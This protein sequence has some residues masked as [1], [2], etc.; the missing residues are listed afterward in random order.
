M[1]ER[2]RAFTFDVFPYQMSQT[3]ALTS[4]ALPIAKLWLDGQFYNLLQKCRNI[5]PQKLKKLFE[6]AKLCQ[7]WRK[8]VAAFVTVNLVNYLLHQ[9]EK[10]QAF[11]IHF[12]SSSKLPFCEQRWSGLCNLDYI[13]DYTSGFQ[14]QETFGV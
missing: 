10:F 14:C 2:K 13:C 12:C 8:V 7:E 9:I 4:R 11:L 1:P 5:I 6:T 3:Y